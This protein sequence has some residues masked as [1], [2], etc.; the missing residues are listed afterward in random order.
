M[1]RN[2]C[3]PAA[4]SCD[5]YR[6]EFVEVGAVLDLSVLLLVEE[7]S[8]ETSND[9]L[10]VPV[11][12]SKCSHLHLARYYQP[13]TDIPSQL[14]MSCKDPSEHPAKRKHPI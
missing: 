13:I 5:G 10:S 9:G 7:R 4:G 12:D 1:L 14:I 8:P 11:L 6:L 2:Q 3:P